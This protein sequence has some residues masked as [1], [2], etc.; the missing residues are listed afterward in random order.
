MCDGVFV[1]S[2][3]Q[4][5]SVITGFDEWKDWNPMVRE[6]VK[7]KDSSVLK[8]KQV[9][10]PSGKKASSTERITKVWVAQNYA[11]CSI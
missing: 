4:V 1:W 10:F 5:W 8:F 7:S 2:G 11:C 3:A 6:V 9:H